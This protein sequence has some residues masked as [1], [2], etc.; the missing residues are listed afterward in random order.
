MMT[1]SLPSDSGS[2]KWKVAGIKLWYLENI[3]DQRPFSNTYDK[4]ANSDRFERSFVNINFNI[5]HPNIN[6][7]QRN[8]DY[9]DTN[10]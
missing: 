5:E 10:Q 4:F 9:L 8:T 2:A 1:T 3:I 6:K 7:V